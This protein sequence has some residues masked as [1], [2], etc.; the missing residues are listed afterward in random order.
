MADSRLTRF[1][2]APSANSVDSYGEGIQPTG[3]PSTSAQPSLHT[4]IDSLARHWLFLA[5][6]FILSIVLSVIVVQ[7]QTPIF[8]ATST[9]L[10]SPP[11]GPV[12]GQDSTDSLIDQITGAAQARNIDT[13]IAILKEQPSI[14]QAAHRLH[15]SEEDAFKAN[16]FVDSVGN[17]NLAEITVEHPSPRIAKSLADEI[18]TDYLDWT[19]QNNQQS[20]VSAGEFLDT[21]L[22]QMNDRLR[23]KEGQLEKEKMRL[24]SP[25][26]VTQ[27]T[28]EVTHLSD[29]ESQLRAAQ[30]AK[31]S[32]E[33]ELVSLQRQL[34]VAEPSIVTSVTTQV[35]PAI[36][37]LQD[38]ISSLEIERTALL[39]RLQPDQP[40]VTDVEG[41]IKDYRNQLQKLI[42]KGLGSKM[43]V[44][45][46]SE[47]PTPM[48]LALLGQISQTRAAVMSDQARISALSSAVDD[49]RRENEALPGKVRVLAA[50]QRDVDQLTEQ[51]QDMLQ[52]SQEV[53]LSKE[54]KLAD[55]EIIRQATIP[56]KPVRPK[57]L[58]IV[59]AS[60]LAGLLLGIFL[61]MIMDSLD[62]T[63]RDP[64]EI[65]ENLG[66]PVLAGVPYLKSMTTTETRNSLP[67]SRAETPENAVTVS[68]D[69]STSALEEGGRLLQAA[70]AFGFP[71][72]PIKTVMITSPLPGEG[73]TTL[74]RQVGRVM[75]ESGQKVLLIDADYRRPGLTQDF[76]A[77][78]YPGFTNLVV[79]QADMDKVLLPT[80][81]PNLTLLP[82]GTLPAN[83]SAF[84][85]SD[86]FAATLDVLR[87]RFDALVIDVPPLVVTDAL[88][89]A[90]QVDG[91]ILVVVP[92]QTLKAAID[93]S[94]ELLNR[95]GARVLGVC[96]NK[97]SRSTV[98]SYYSYYGY[99]YYGYG[100]YDK[101]RTTGLTK[102]DSAEDDDA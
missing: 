6:C 23:D 98:N 72:Q 102:T 94:V 92:G 19:R 12:R 63:L 5:L 37:Q 22:S 85:R 58:Q 79:G 46:Q 40:E 59:L 38:K 61:I 44:T 21:H 27:T 43:V 36:T 11:T 54:A 100:Y 57:K 35:D 28:Q 97:V 52:K 32:D 99:G 51:Y 81:T 24:G 45:G 25:D 88:F 39:R 73:K 101:Y 15:I 69:Y 82:S 86:R 18:A 93:R 62:K 47:T 75:A 17:T 2:S 95:V 70:M 13:Q 84:I 60:S 68:D 56:L 7:R 29:F 48:R 90:K 34:S 10:I 74:S 67:G 31:K 76:D 30:A 16:V 9:L 91:V 71:D 87:S 8:S 3:Y 65:E 77:A 53:Q 42:Q 4:F 80:A 20:L 55:G 49:L 83:P 1:Q 41:Q 50:L 66:L 96:L 64:S 78:K 26:I 89:L 14:K 33:A